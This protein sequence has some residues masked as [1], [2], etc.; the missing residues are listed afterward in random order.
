MTEEIKNGVAF[1]RSFWPT[2]GT[3]I[4][5]KPGEGYD[6]NDLWEDFPDQASIFVA[7]AILALDPHY[8]RISLNG[9]EPIV[10]VG[11]WSVGGDLLVARRCLSSLIEEACKTYDVIYGNAQAEDVRQHISNV[12]KLEAIFAGGKKSLHALLDAWAKNK[13]T[14][15]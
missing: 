9:A 15:G 2:T 1:D 12:E 5:S 13:G 7:E 14:E 3:K 4:P 11:I 10:E 6:L 8:M